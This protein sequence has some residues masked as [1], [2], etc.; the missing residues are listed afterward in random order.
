MAKTRREQIEEMLA[1]DP[2][3][4][5]LRYGLAMEYVSAEDDEGALQ[6]FR[7][8][9]AVAPTYVPGYLQAGQALVRL[10]RTAE[11]AT[12]FRDGI[13]VARQKGDLHALGEMEGMLAELE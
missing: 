9:F 5:F 11:A 12:M 2:N 1:T 8:L 3:D 7:E 6:R 10:G 13:T 4:P